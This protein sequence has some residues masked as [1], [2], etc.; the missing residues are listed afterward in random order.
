MSGKNEDFKWSYL[1]HFGKNMW[2]D[3]PRPM[4]K[5]SFPWKHLSD[6]EFAA[7]SSDRYRSLSRV[8]FDEPVWRDI[9]EELKANGCNQIVIDVG[10][11]LRYPSHPELAVEGSWSQ[12]RLSAEVSRLKNMGFDVVPKLNFSATHHSW[13]GPY[14]RLTSTPEYYRV[15]G[16]LIRDT[17]ETFGE[18]KSFHLGFDEEDIPKY[19]RFN[20]LLVIRQ[21]ELWWHD[22][23]WFVGQVEKRGVQA[24][25]WHDYTR[26]HPIEDFVKNMPK[27]VLQSPWAYMLEWEK[28]DYL[29]HKKKRLDEMLAL[30]DAGYGVIPCGSNLFGVPESFALLS[31]WCAE[32][33]CGPCFKGM[34]NAPWL[35]TIEPCRKLF[36]H[37]TECFSDAR[38]RFYAK[39]KS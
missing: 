25:I 28:P 26:R 12:E 29:K 8:R 27:S 10:E 9:S 37:E 22:V 24:W 4:S 11:F 33:L 14:V 17:L 32:N 6:E 30:L 19:Q 3:K 2:G 36:R 20:S 31:E 34:L 7:A 23:N 38:R 1:V 16:D 35:T 18:T 39:R 21:G 15:C 5:T 13:L